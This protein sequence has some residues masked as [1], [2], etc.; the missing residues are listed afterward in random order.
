MVLTI[1]VP[2]YVEFAS[3]HDYHGVQ[4]EVFPASFSTECDPDLPDEEV[5]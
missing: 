3:E 4:E 5:E 1:D 2:V